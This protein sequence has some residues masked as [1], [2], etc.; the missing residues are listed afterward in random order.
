MS[1]LIATDLDGT[2]IPEGTF[3]INPEYYEVIRKLHDQ[4]DVFVA[5]SGR[6]YT[7]I[8]SLLE[9]VKD[10]IICLCGN[11]TYVAC[12]GVSMDVKALDPDLYHQVLQ[13][14]RQEGGT[15]ICA[16]TPES[17]WTDSEDMDFFRTMSGGYR[18]SLKK[19]P[20]LA[21]LD[22]P[23]A[24]ARLEETEHPRERAVLKVA[25]HTDSDAGPTARKVRELY[26]ARANIL[27]AGAQWV[28][29][30]PLGADKG[31]ALAR[32]QQ[33][34]GFSKEDTIAFGDNGNDIGM[35]RLAGDSFCV[36]NGRAEVKAAADT[37]IGEMKDDAVLT[38]LKK[39][40][41]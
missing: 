18:M 27:C 41:R 33:Q 7:S 4:G 36:A 32:I 3:D 38:V 20:D 28:D 31:S 24:W 16:D 14:M 34:L 21:Q 39:L 37:V 5:A 9:P 15:F 40:L 6:H 22:D 8:C 26:G 10:D 23:S 2:I 11:G 30:V 35:L 19:Y 25:L 17:V 1:R 13:T 12:R 29:C